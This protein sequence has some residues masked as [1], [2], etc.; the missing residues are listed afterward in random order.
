MAERESEREA[1]ILKA[2]QIGEYTLLNSEKLG[3]A[4]DLIEGLVEPANAE[5]GSIVAA[6]KKLGQEAGTLA[7]YDRFGGA[8][9][10]GER[11][12]AIGTFYDFTA[13]E[14]RKDVEISEE[15]Y[16]DEFVLTKKKTRK[17]KKSEDVG[18]RIKRLDRTSKKSKSIEAEP[19]EAQGT[20]DE[21][22]AVEKAPVKK[23]RKGKK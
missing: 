1:R 14:P 2:T 4:L 8:V 19:E 13:R 6:C 12:L 21:E 16:T 23:T 5:E 10:L 11:K 3:R 15:S 7:L 9:K 17:G 22:T 18:D 20:D